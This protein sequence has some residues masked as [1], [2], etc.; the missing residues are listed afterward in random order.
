VRVSRAAADEG[1]Q[2]GGAGEQ[3]RSA[4]VW[5]SEERVTVHERGT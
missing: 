1:E 3:R 2:S 5:A 4:A